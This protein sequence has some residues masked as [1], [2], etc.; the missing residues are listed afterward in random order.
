MKRL[1]KIFTV[2]A[3]VFTVIIPVNPVKAEE[4]SDNIFVVGM[5]CNY[6]PF[7]WTQVN[8]TETTVPLEGGGYADGY[9]VT[10]A[11]A[12]AKY[13]GK[14]LV[15][16]K[17]SWDGL[18]PALQAGVIDAVIA[19]MTDTADRRQRVDF[20]QTYYESQMVLIVRKGDKLENAKSLKDFSNKKVLGQLNT[21]YDTVIDQIPNVKHATALED[22]PAMVMQLNNELVDAVTAEL[23]VAAGIIATNPDLT[24]VEF[25]DGKGFDVDLT[26][27]SVSIAISKENSKLKEEINNY[28]DTLSNE[29][30]N[31]MMDEAIKR[32]PATIT[33]LSDNIFIAAKQIFEV[34]SPLFFS[35]IGSTLTLAFGGTILGLLIGLVIGAIRAIK[36]EERDR[37]V[38]KIIKRVT[39]IITTIYIEIFRGT[40]MMVQG[41]FIYYGLKNIIH[42]D[43]FTAG[44][45]VI[46]INTGAYMAEIVRSGIQSVDK[47]QSEAARSI[48]MNNI[49]TMVYVI[50]PQAIKNSF[51]SIGN[52]F[53]INIKDS[54]VLN[55]IAVTELFYQAKSVAGSLYAFVPTYFVVALIYLCLTFPTTRIL[56]YIENKMNSKKTITFDS[57]GGIK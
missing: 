23:P 53:V 18:E 44:I 57:E 31:I 13:L 43:P 22:Y 10:I 11:Q 24:Y 1:L 56:N 30:K 49:Q 4:E 45:F 54:S 35:G 39:W 7:N 6:A 51:P 21:L 26:D 12:I 2:L 41:A 29:D 34:Y 55:V 32:I 16:K 17:M 5:E 25:K 28:L 33:S 48:G 3:L 8:E 9:D 46:T 40:P 50:L 52:E 36:V 19:G 14:E 47:G 42:W 27:T 15:I 37:L 20:T 38:S